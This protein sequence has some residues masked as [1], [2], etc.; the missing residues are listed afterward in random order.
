MRKEGCKSIS[1]H[2]TTINATIAACK[3]YYWIT[4]NIFFVSYRK[5]AHCVDVPIDD[6]DNHEDGGEKVEQLG[7]L[8]D[9]T[10]AV[11]YVDKSEAQ[12]KLGQSLGNNCE[13]WSTWLWR[14]L[15]CRTLRLTCTAA[16]CMTRPARSGWSCDSSRFGH[17]CHPTIFKYQFNDQN[18]YRRYLIITTSG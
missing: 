12:D 17:R 10:R 6:V 14:C 7:A 2:E 18:H 9:Q 16:C 3:I 15:T 5:R 8:F 4:W 11:T 13:L 1:Q